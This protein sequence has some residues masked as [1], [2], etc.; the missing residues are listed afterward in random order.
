M[1]EALRSRP[2][3]NLWL[4]Q[5][6]STM[7]DELYKMAYLWIAVEELGTRAGYVT[8]LQLAIVVLGALA[9]GHWLER[10]R[11]DR[12]L[13]G[14]DWLRAGFCLI[15]AIFLFAGIRS[16][17]VL[18]GSTL[19]I[20]ALGAVFDPALQGTI[21]LLSRSAR[22]RKAGNNL[23][24]TTYRLS[25]VVAPFLIGMLSKVIPLA[26][27]FVIDA[28]TFLLSAISLRS[29]GPTLSQAIPAESQQNVRKRNWKRGISVLREHPQVLRVLLAK[30]FCA[31]L[32]YLGYTL[33]FVLLAREIDSSGL[34]TYGLIMASYGAGNLGSALL[35]GSFERKRTEEWVYLGIILIGGAFLMMALSSSLVWICIF[36]AICATGGPL[37][38]TPMLELVQDRIRPEDQFAV[39]RMRMALENGFML[40][41]SLISPL[42]L[43]LAGTRTTLLLAGV[44]CLA[45]VLVA[46][47]QKRQE[48]KALLFKSANEL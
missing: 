35:F 47:H 26:A 14:I 2:L 24:A 9:G 16:L 43:A 33:G 40:L 3:R 4:G 18:I 28:I 46:L 44:L 31:G 29:V 32:W 23:M 15:P 20:T 39:L 5:V 48:S 22:E 27:F 25:R 17:P 36:A 34:M 21:P 1:L 11:L 19:A 8:S 30:S 12:A 13:I 41:F 7:G 10:R 37:N 45:T 6:G 42:L 38:D